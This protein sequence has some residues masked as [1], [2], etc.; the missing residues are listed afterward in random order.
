ML[1]LGGEVQ[2]VGVVHLNL[3]ARGAGAGG[4]EN[5]KLGE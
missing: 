4:G 2:N 3:K 5:L 1:N